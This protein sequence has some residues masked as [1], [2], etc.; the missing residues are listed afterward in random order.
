[1]S[2]ARVFLK[3]KHRDTEQKSQI[4]SVV[5]EIKEDDDE[6]KYNDQMN[7]LRITIKQ[8]GH[9]SQYN[10]GESDIDI[11]HIEDQYFPST[12]QSYYDSQSYNSNTKRNT[13]KNTQS[14]DSSLLY[15]GNEDLYVRQERIIANYIPN[16]R[17][18]DVSRDAKYYD[19]N[20]QLNNIYNNDG[21]TGQFYNPNLNSHDPYSRLR[22]HIDTFHF[23]DVHESQKYPTYYNNSNIRHPNTQEQNQ[24]FTP[25]SVYDET[26][27]YDYHDLGL[28]THRSNE[29]FSV[30]NPR[31]L[32]RKPMP[33]HIDESCT[34]EAD[35]ESKSDKR[36]G[37][38]NGEDG[39]SIRFITNNKNNRPDGADR[40][41][42]LN[43]SGDSSSSFTSSSVASS[44]KKK[45]E[46]VNDTN[47]IA[48]SPNRSMTDVS[49]YFN[50]DDASVY[51]GG[52][53]E[54]NDGDEKEKDSRLNT[55]HSPLNKT[56]SSNYF[57]D[58]SSVYVGDIENITGG[59]T[60][61]NIKNK[62]DDEVYSE[63]PSDKESF[64]EY[65]KD[66]LMSLS[67]DIEDF[68]D[69]SEREIL[70]FQAEKVRRSDLLPSF[71]VRSISHCIQSNVLISFIVFFSTY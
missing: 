55:L 14:S 25:R 30:D 12:E 68:H 37:E 24:N 7:D 51:I 60:G 46:K 5:C 49:K 59:V 31:C 42:N 13:I 50:E 28:D 39:P 35:I 33:V 2:T 57:N 21:N 40:N 67:G 43:R 19:N 26:K 61:I 41:L 1:M 15:F 16:L 54:F 20:F 52:I 27:Y 10:Y 45:R 29:S 18:P 36:R 38:N 53:E 44:E 23:N 56:R 48:L 64:F 58:D 47:S 9:G 22:S 34:Y 6:E 17:K 62:N 71:Y 11:G 3:P 63:C 69:I 66:D 4:S 32:K 65:E 8:K 70:N